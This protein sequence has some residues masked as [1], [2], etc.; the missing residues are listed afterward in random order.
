MDT[1]VIVESGTYGIVRH[2]QFLGVILIAGGSIII[3]QHWLFGA[4]GILIIGIVPNWIHEAE[5]NLILKFGDNYKRYM[6][7]VPQMNVFL[8][9][10][11]F[12]QRRGNRVH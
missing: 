2:P 12:L 9:I 10:L 6:E 1:T 8:G 11:R 4:I 7:R 5:E 3:S